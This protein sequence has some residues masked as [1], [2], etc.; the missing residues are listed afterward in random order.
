MLKTKQFTLFFC[1]F[2]ASICWGQSPKWH[3][4]ID[5]PNYNFFQVQDAFYE[6]WEGQEYESGK[7]YK[8]FKRYEYLMENRVDENGHYDPTR[9]QREFMNYL[10]THQN[11]ATERSM[12]N[13]TLVGPTSPT[14]TSNAGGIGRIDCMTFHPTDNDTYWAGSPS[15]GLW[16]T[17]DNGA[18]WTT[19][20][21]ILDGLGVADIVVDPTNTDVMYL[22]TGD[23]DH[24]AMSTYGVLKSIDG[25]ATWST[26]GLSSVYR[27]YRLLI[28]PDNT[29][30]LVAATYYG[31]YRST[32]FGATWTNISSVPSSRIYYMEAKPNDPKTIYASS[33]NSGTYEFYKSTN[34]GASFIAQT[35]PFGSGDVVRGA[36]GVTADAPNNVYLACNL[37]STS[38]LQGIYKSTD[39]GDSFT[40]ITAPTAV[41]EYVNGDPYSS[42]L[43]TLLGNQGWYDWM[44]QVNSNN[45]DE[46]LIGAVRMARTLD[47][48]STWQYLSTS[49]N[50]GAG[51]HVDFHYAKY[52]PN[53]GEAFV[54]CDGGVWRTNGL[55]GLWT[56]L[57]DGLICTQNYTFSTCLTDPSLMLVGNQDNNTWLKDGAAWSTV[58]GGDGMGC[59]IDPGNPDIMYSSYQSGNIYRTFNRFGGFSTILNASMTGQSSQWVTQFDMHP[60]WRNRLFAIYQDVWYSDDFGDNW[61][62]V[63]TFGSS[64]TLTILEISPSDPDVIYTGTS[65]SQYR[66]TDGGASWNPIAYPGKSVSDIAIHATNP[67]IIWASHFNGDVSQ[68]TN[69]GTSWTDV[70]GTLPNITANTIVYQ[71]DSPDGLYLGMD[72]G[73]YYTDNTLSDWILLGNGLPNVIVED[74]EINYCAGVVRAATYGRAT[75]ER[76]LYTFNASTAC[77]P[78]QSPATLPSGDVDVCGLTSVDIMAD[79]APS[80]YSYE[81]YQDGVLMTGM[82]SQTLT[83]TTPGSYIVR[84]DNGSDCGSYHSDPINVTFTSAGGTCQFTGCEDLNPNTANGPGTTTVLNVFGPYPTIGGPVVIC[85]NQ[86]GD[87]SYSGEVFDVYDESNTLQGQT[88]FDGD[89]SSSPSTDFCF[90]VTAATF[91]TWAADNQI[92]ITF[93]PVSTAI[94]PNLCGTN[95]VCA[96]LD[97]PVGVGC[98]PTVYVPTGI[99]S[100]TYA[101]ANNVNSDGAVIAGENVVFQAGTDIDLNPNFEVPLSAEFLAH[102][103]ACFASTSNPIIALGANADEPAIDLST[104]EIEP[105][106]T[107]DYSIKWGEESLVSLDLKQ[108]DLTSI[109][110]IQLKN[111]QG[112]VVN[113]FSYKNEKYQ[114]TIKNLQTGMYML[115]VQFKNDQQ[116]HKVVFDENRSVE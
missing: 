94:N 35:L 41:V 17:T 111:I 52:H 81:W 89:C 16:K 75:W 47:G 18:S 67:N 90:T 9:S 95:R 98:A 86:Q 102:I 54:G 108:Q 31:I 82:N 57:N 103:V 71:A 22:A 100:G 105:E 11:D 56:P 36:I 8:Q 84:F 69:G 42:D 30:N 74:L 115:I 114:S 62:Q 44:F 14:S 99:T 76:D 112:E 88:N 78:L 27:I 13:W 25:G 83:V 43:G 2:L 96:T 32:D 55:T 20:T 106:S 5:D 68:S 6:E 92:T 3:T 60:F 50:D 107:L 46:M 33:Y 101:A 23:R 93:D 1:L 113:T 37:P 26:S 7:G 34:G 58:S 24:Y 61:T 104:V 97:V 73:V 4:M 65:S 38:G 80:G 72:K 87:N 39:S 29:K 49:A 109:E 91:S 85:V 15:G 12:M 63:S 40:L 64:A 70:S 28:D 10:K 45:D 79:P 21:D 51:I 77:C 59:W 110:S 19:N 116:V 48:G 53:T 66:S